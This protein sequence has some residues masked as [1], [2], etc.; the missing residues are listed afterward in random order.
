VGAPMIAPAGERDLAET[1]LQVKITLSRVTKPPVWRRLQIPADRSLDEVHEVIQ[2]AFGWQDCHLHVFEMNGEWFGPADPDLELDCADER[3]FMFA[4]LMA[5]GDRVTYTYDFGDDWRHEIRL[6]NRLD[7]LPGVS[8]PVLVKAKGGCPP[9]DC[10]GAW[11]YENLKAVL[12]DPDAE[13]HREMCEW[14]GLDDAASF[15]PAAVDDETIRSR[16]A[17]IRL[18]R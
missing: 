17:A 14:L 2:A 11:G 8:Y 6:E 12:T 13:G 1:I 5:A 4:E 18:R 3:E 16:L 10:G 7:A 15:D 9:E